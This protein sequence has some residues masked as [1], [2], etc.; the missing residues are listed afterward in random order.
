MDDLSVIVSHPAKQGNV[1]HRPRAAAL[2]GFRTRFLTGLY[3]RPGR[4]P[5][6]LVGML[7]ERRRRR[8]LVE[9]EKRRIDGLADSDVVSLLGPL[10]EATLRPRGYYRAWHQTHDRLASWWL[11]S[12][13]RPAIPTVLHCFQDS[14]LETLRTGKSKGMRTVLEI[15]LPPLLDPRLLDVDERERSG[16]PDSTRLRAEIGAADYVLV[17]SEFSAGVAVALGADPRRLVRQHLGVDTRKYFPRTSDR[18]PGP[19]RILFLGGTSRRKGVHHLFEAWAQGIEGAELLIGGNRVQG[20]DAFSTRLPPDSRLLG[21]IPDA[22]FPAL[23]RNAD[24]LVN[25]SLSEGGSNVVYEALASG[26]PCVI[27][28][29]ASSAVRHGLDGLV[30][31]VG[32]PVALR[33]ALVS[34]CRDPELLARMSRSARARAES[35]NWDRY[36]VSLAGIYKKL[37]NPDQTPELFSIVF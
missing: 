25:P 37:G 36:A 34:L 6:N 35:L 12:R 13:T 15:T 19:I 20:L 3:Y 8:L 2:A 27:S 7:P 1:Y 29:N 24:I 31:D 5:W 32:D 16:L 11:R 14:A 33:H 28:R 10:L 26:V 23:I 22:D 9:L 30:V 21:H 17:Q 4:I 18:S